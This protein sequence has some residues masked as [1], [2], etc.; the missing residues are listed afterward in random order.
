MCTQICRTHGKTYVLTSPMAKTTIV[1][2]KTNWAV[3]A[4]DEMSES[5]SEKTI[6]T[7]VITI[8]VRLILV[9][10]MRIG[11]VGI[12]SRG[13]ATPKRSI[14]A[15]RAARAV[16][17]DCGVGSCGSGREGERIL[18]L[19]RLIARGDIAAGI[20]GRA[21]KIMRGRRRRVA[22]KKDAKERMRNDRDR[23]VLAVVTGFIPLLREAYRGRVEDV[24]KVNAMTKMP[25]QPEGGELD[26]P[27]SNRKPFAW[28]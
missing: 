5:P 4:E 24:E 17:I 22:Q 12:V 27:P 2:P 23:G 9:R 6:I 16:W 21:A 15:E 13:W 19:D 26:E 14:E 3:N 25:F 20:F 8:R 1:R 18:G 28:A 11:N 10:A 7:G